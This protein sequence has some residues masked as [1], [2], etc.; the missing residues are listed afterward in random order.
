MKLTVFN[1]SPRGGS[2]NTQVL[3]GQLAE[4]FQQTQGNS[5]E[6]I[7]L[8]DEKDLAVSAA[9][10][11]DSDIVLLAFPLYIDS[12]PAV[13]K[14]FIESLQPLCGR[15]GNPA[16]GFVVISGFPEAIHTANIK[17]YLEKLAARLGC[18]YIG[19]ITKGNAEGIRWGSAK[20][21]QKIFQA[22]RGFG[23]NLAYDGKFDEAAVKE[24]A[25]PPRFPGHMAAVFNF[26]RML[27]LTDAGWNN[28][29]KKNKAYEKRYDRPYAR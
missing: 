4:G 13:V 21:N 18:R 14:E 27:G 7:C 28:M 6:F 10:F 26:F 8:K 11:A 2:G 22:F 1:G 24:L 12:T 17:R 19:T 20:Q 29:L 5:V 3:L 15:P 25:G 9:R 23:R 16:L